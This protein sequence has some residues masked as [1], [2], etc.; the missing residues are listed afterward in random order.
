MAII[1]KFINRHGDYS[2]IINRHGDYSKFINRHRGIIGTQDTRLSRQ[3]FKAFIHVQ[4]AAHDT[5]L[6]D[7]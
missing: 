2:K 6:C 4:P 3:H 1:Q 7:P 5:A